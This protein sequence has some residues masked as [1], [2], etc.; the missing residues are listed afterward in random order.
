MPQPKQTNKKGI[1]KIQSE[2]KRN[3]VRKGNSLKLV[4]LKQKGEFEKK[5]T[6]QVE[7]EDCRAEE[8]WEGEK[9]A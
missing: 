7:K 3:S 1:W 6:E 9:P 8:K 2:I 5:R 4:H